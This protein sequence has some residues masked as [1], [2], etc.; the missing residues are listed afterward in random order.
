MAL[1]QDISS[2]PSE[3]AAMEAHIAASL[4]VPPGTASPD[5]SSLRPAVESPATLTV[6]ATATPAST[7]TPQV[8]LAHAHDGWLSPIELDERATPL[9]TATPVPKARAA[10]SQGTGSRR[11]RRASD[12]G[13]LPMTLG[14]YLELLDWTGRQLRAGTKGLIPASLARSSPGSRCQPR[15][16]WRRSLVRPPVP[17]RCGAGRAS[18]SRGPAPGSSPPARPALEPDGFRDPALSLKR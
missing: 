17:S 11:S 1:F 9:L 16:G 7:S 18:G 6:P 8:P 10:A 2:A 5:K 15:A 4:P 3:A 13:L 14:K 12:R